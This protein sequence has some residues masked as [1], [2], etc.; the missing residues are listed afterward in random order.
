MTI[1]RSG[2]QSFVN[3]NQPPATPGDFASMNPRATALAVDLAFRAAA[4]SALAQNPI[5]G[6][7]AWGQGQFASSQLPVGSSVLG[8]VAD[9]LQTVIPFPPSNSNPVMARTAVQE[10]FPVSLFTRG[11]F[12]V[13]PDL[14]VAGI[15]SAGDTVYA[16]PDDGAPTNDSAFFSATGVQTAATNIVTISAVTKGK[17]VPG[18]RLAGTGVDAGLTVLTQATGTA[19]GAG[20]YTVSTTTGF[21]STTVTTA[22]TDTGFKFA[23]ATDA[24][25]SFT[26]VVA[27]GTG[28]LTVSALTGVVQIGANLSGTGVPANTFIRSQ[29]TGTTGLAGTYQLNTIGPAIG[30]TAMT[31]AVGKL[32]MITK[33]L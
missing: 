23:S 28:V 24:D 1:S 25:A 12:W 17:L 31:S 10:G 2:F 16:N 19:G 5:V 15:V 21:A 26:G 11:D 22:A 3:R 20:T 30:S 27:A 14:P 9:E 4:A 8:F 32:A 33:T 13:S 18:M 7:F 6:N 29:L